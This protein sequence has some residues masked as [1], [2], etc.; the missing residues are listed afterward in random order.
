MKQY[1]FL[2]IICLIICSCNSATLDD[3]ELCKDYSVSYHEIGRVKSIEVLRDL[4]FKIKVE[5]CIPELIGKEIQIEFGSDKT[6]IFKYE[7]NLRN[8]ISSQYNTLIENED[9]AITISIH[10]DT[11]KNNLKKLSKKKYYFVIHCEK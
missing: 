9:F 7:T 5:K 3:S 6:V 8:I 1:L 11:L 2:T 4:D 10:L